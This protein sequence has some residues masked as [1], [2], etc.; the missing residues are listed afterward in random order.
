MRTEG[1]P[2]VVICSALGINRSTVYKRARG[3][4]ALT[5]T[6]QVDE[7]LT[8]KI[9]SL[10][11]SEETFGYRRVWAHLR[12]RDNLPVNVKKVHRI[13]KLRGWQCRLWHRPTQV[14]RATKTK[15]STVE[16][17][18]TLWCTDMTKVYCG[19]DGWASMIAVID[20]GSRE[21]VGYRFSRRGRA[22][23]AIDA[24]EQAVIARY[25]CLK[26]PVTLT[27]RSDN[28]SIFL[29]REF[30][31]TAKRLGIHQEFTPRYS[32][33]YNGSIERFFRTMKQ[34]CVWLRR[35]A[36]FEEAEAALTEW[37]QHYNTRRLHSSLGYMTPQQWRQQF[38][39]PLAA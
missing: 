16:R 26:S 10:L 37:V 25:G 3:D 21:I 38:Y 2:L 6:A 7:E 4:D 12:Y 32:P 39:L 35:F 23:E 8:T 5:N 30:V 28:G 15:Q 20:A 17:P 11:D 24:L 14:P 9:R 18:D 29:A 13:M 1:Y 19:E 22:V 33:E 34:E 27:L 36:S 31:K